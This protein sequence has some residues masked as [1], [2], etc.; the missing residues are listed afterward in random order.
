VYRRRGSLLPV[1]Y[2]NQVLGLKPAGDTEVVSMVVLQAEDRQFGL[3]VDG[4]NDTQEIVVKP[5]GK[6]LKGLTVYAGATI[7]GDG[8]VALILDVLGIGQ[9]S[10][11]LAES[12]EQSRAVL[13]QKTESGT[14]QQRLLLFSAG[15]Y[16][17]LAVPLSLVARLEEFPLKSIEHA[18]GCQVVQYRNRIL[19][20]VS[21]RAALEG[22]GPAEGQTS[23][24]VQVIVFNDGDRSIGL[25]VDQILDV[26]EEAVVVRQKTHRK[27]LLGS[28]VVGKRV[29]DFLD[30]NQV[31][32]ATTENWFEGSDGPGSG[33]RVLVAEPSAFSRGLI[34]GGL[35]MAGYQV[36]EAAN[37]DELIR[38]LERH[39]VDVVIAALDLLPNG[40][41]ALR[42]AMRGRP[43]WEAIPVLALADS[44]AQIVPPNPQT[45]FQDCQAKFDGEAILESVSRLAAALDAAEK[46]PQYAGEK[47]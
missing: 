26:A 30:L 46:E 22:E 10:G 3:V 19:P 11:V 32:R 4:I 18:S 38:G 41:S 33:K 28:A 9:L 1:A 23:D 6:Q 25:M 40:G 29:T 37:L 36:R 16:E 5:L 44:A 27:G 24:P 20:L 39:P 7:M 8:R 17:R 13:D 35:D 42:A 47:R 2:L 21:L 31:I 15:S 34:R 45:A 43:E 14:E 12:R